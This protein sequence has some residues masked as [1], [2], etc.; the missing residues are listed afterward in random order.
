V[1]PQLQINIHTKFPE[2]KPHKM[3]I[4]VN[5]T[6]KEILQEIKNKG[7]YD[8]VQA[9]YHGVN[10]LSQLPDYQDVL[11]SIKYKNFKYVIGNSSYL[12]EIFLEDE[13]LHKRI[14]QMFSYEDF[15]IVIKTGSLV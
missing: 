11:D 15:D 14:S 1:E 2:I 7:E 6:T 3:I 8:F 9:L 12:S 10:P 5:A 4:M 13:S